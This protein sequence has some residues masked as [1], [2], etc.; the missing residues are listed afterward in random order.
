MRLYAVSS[1]MVERILVLD[2][3]VGGGRPAV[4]TDGINFEEA[5]AYGDLLDVNMIRTNHIAAMMET[6]GIEAARAALVK[7]VSRRPNPKRGQE[8]LRRGSGERV[9]RGSGEGQERGSGER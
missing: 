3:G 4:Q 8:G 6:Y 5:W 1:Q 9:R 7:E 2:E